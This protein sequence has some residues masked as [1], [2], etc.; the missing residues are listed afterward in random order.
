MPTVLKNLPSKFLKRD[1]ECSVREDATITEPVLKVE[2][3]KNYIS[4]RVVY[5]ILSGNTDK[6]FSI[7]SHSGEISVSNNLDY[8]TETYY[9]LKIKAS[10]STHVMTTYVTINI[11]NVNDNAP[12]FD[13]F[14]TIIYLP[15]DDYNLIRNPLLYSEFIN[16][17]KCITT[18]RASDRDMADGDQHIVFSTSV[19][20]DG[21]VVSTT[22][23]ESIND[24]TPLF[25][26]DKKSGCLKMK[27]PF[28]NTDEYW[29]VRKPK[30]SNFPIWQV[31]VNANDDDG[32]PDS[33]QISVRVI[34]RVSKRYYSED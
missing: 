18:A 29:K 23:G 14:R 24:Q 17:G 10:N 5:S 19:P 25:F 12:V 1:Y 21:T 30:L 28:A 26:I 4:G 8:E 31:I 27:K 15:D 16:G 22:P 20:E 11:D 2:A 6:K 13:L 33:K 3:D 7:D 32:S 9:R 34:V